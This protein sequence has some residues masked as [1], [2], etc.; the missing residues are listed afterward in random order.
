[1][2]NFELNTSD[3]ANG[4]QND[5]QNLLFF[6]SS[7]FN[8]ESQTIIPTVYRD[9]N[10]YKLKHAFKRQTKTRHSKNY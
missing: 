7:K 2:A 10:H 5:L 6:D 3:D 9:F 1:M 4:N 8:L